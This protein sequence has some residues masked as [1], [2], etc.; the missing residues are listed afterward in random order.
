LVVLRARRVLQP[1]SFSATTGIHVKRDAI[2]PMVSSENVFSNRRQ[3]S[4]FTNLL[5]NLIEARSEAEY[6]CGGERISQMWADTP[7]GGSLECFNPASGGWAIRGRLNRGGGGVLIDPSLHVSRDD[8]DAPTCSV[9]RRR[10]LSLQGSNSGDIV[11][12]LPKDM[13]PSHRA[14]LSGCSQN[15]HLRR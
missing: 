10:R 3:L 2:R 7:P 6:E 15:A 8:Y 11:S 12:P 9:G 1:V 14:L 5:L 4:K 13:V